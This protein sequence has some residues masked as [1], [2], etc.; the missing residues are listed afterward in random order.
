MW[1]CEIVSKL[2]RLAKKEEVGRGDFI[3]EMRIN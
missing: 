2:K 3:R 1:E